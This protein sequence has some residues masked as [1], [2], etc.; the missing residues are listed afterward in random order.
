MPLTDYSLNL[1]ADEITN[2]T[3]QVRLHTAD[4]GTAG[5]TSRIGTVSQDVAAAGWSAAT[6]GDSTNLAAI[7]FGVLSAS[8]SFDVS[9]YSVWDGANFMGRESLSASVT[10]AANETFS[11]NASTLTF[12]GSTS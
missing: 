11:I 8:A 5:T 1:A 7:D 10:V 3:V 2:R 6:G 4:A 9:H 12:M